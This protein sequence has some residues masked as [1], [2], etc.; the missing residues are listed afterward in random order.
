[1]LTGCPRCPNGADEHRTAEPYGESGG[2]KSVFKL[3][4]AW[5]IDSHYGSL[6]ALQAAFCV[7]RN[8]ESPVQSRLHTVVDKQVCQDALTTIFS[9]CGLCVIEPTAA[10]KFR[11]Y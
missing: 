5:S 2:L 7:M 9:L 11:L 3:L 8:I 10:D 6:C 1:M 4:T